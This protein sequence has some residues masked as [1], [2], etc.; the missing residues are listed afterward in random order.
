MKIYF[1][2]HGIAEAFA[3]SDFEREL[4]TEGRIKLSE[5]FDNFAREFTS[6]DYKIY[7]SPLVRAIQTCEIL[8]E[9]LNTDYEIKD[10][11]AG[12]SLKT[13]L[14][15]LRESGH[16]T[17]ILVGHE[18]YISDYLYKITGK[19]QTVSRGSIHEVEI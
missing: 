16:S 6:D 4:T 8:C 2:R 15:D 10:Y 5:T 17:Y 1:I 9:K 14:S 11:L 18:P 12:S 13:V 19:F 7:S 3:N